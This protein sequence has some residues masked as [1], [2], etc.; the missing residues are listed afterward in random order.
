[1]VVALCFLLEIA[2]FGFWAGLVG[3]AALLL[4]LLLHECGHILVAAAF[5]VPVREFGISVHG[6]YIIRAHGLRRR[7][8]VLISLAGPLMNLVLIVPSL[9]LPRIGIQIAFCNLSLCALNLLP[10]PSSDGLRIARSI[11]GSGWP[12]D[13][14]PS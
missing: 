4:S 11:W 6:A 1:M 13:A 8:D 14:M 10:I 2:A 5:N 3:G 12:F 9:F 7:D